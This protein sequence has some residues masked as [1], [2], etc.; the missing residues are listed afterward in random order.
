MH[1]DNFQGLAVISMLFKQLKTLK[2]DKIVFN[3]C[4][5]AKLRFEITILCSMSNCVH[6]YANFTRGMLGNGTGHLLKCVKLY[7]ALGR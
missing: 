3:R 6:M 2:L 4:N 1:N 5:Y 7:T